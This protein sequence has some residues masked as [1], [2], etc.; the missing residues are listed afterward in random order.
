MS[1][2]IKTFLENRM[3]LVFNI[4]NVKCAY[5]VKQTIGNTKKYFLKFEMR[6]LWTL[7]FP[8]HRTF[9]FSVD[10]IHFK[11]LIKNVFNRY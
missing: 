1:R 7:S 9:S 3:I 6:F 5:K 4:Y 10:D 11:I 8:I 2:K